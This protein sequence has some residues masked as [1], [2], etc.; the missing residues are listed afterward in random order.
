[1][2]ISQ[3]TTTQATTVVASM[4]TPVA[5]GA[6]RPGARGSRQCWCQGQILV[7]L[8]E[9]GWILPLDDI[10]D[11]A[12]SKNDGRVYVDTLDIKGGAKLSEGDMVGFYVYV[13]EL[14]LQAEDVRCLNKPAAPVGT[15]APAQPK[16]S[17]HPPAA[18]MVPY[19]VKASIP[20]LSST[21]KMLAIN[22]QNAIQA[23]FSDDSDS[24]AESDS[25]ADDSDDAPT[26]PVG[27]AAKPRSLSPVASTT[28]GLSSD[29]E[30]DSAC[31]PRS[32]ELPEACLG[33]QKFHPPPGL[34]LS[35]PPTRFALDILA[36]AG[37]SAAADPLDILVRAREQKQEQHKKHEP[38]KSPP[39]KTPAWTPAYRRARLAAA[40]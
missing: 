17:L 6:R 1:M 31:S 38:Q 20:N 11:A 39:V 3:K 30:T 5:S 18:E 29:D 13:D 35:S 10:D 16:I 27:K 33:G 4:T 37:L 28:A 40:A 26:L 8:A 24:D 12:L 2:A 7:M 34:T 36:R 22:M 19:G 9:M 32:E 25:D 15:K 14:G 23:Y 21:Q